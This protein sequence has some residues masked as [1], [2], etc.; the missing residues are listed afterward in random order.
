MV[1]E[2]VWLCPQCTEVLGW[3]AQTCKSCRA[4]II[5]GLPDS[6]ETALAIVAFLLYILVLALLATYTKPL[7]ALIVGM[8]FAFVVWK[9]F[10][11]DL[12]IS[13]RRADILARKPP[14][15]LSVRVSIPSL[16]WGNPKF[17][18]IEA[19]KVIV[20]LEQ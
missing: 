3:G 15:D 16:F 18:A 2:I 17:E 4:K 7:V 20:L 9:M 12:Q 1:N 14:K 6:I 10:R 8:P 13:P 19:K 11:G 5:R